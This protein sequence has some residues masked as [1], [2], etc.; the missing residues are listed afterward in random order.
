[1][2]DYIASIGS[3]LLAAFV[4][5][6]TK[7]FADPGSGLSQDP[8][9]WP[10]LLTALLVLLSVLLLVNASRDKKEIRF[11]VNGP[12]LL[13]IGK[14]FA[15]LIVYIAA[16]LLLMPLLDRIFGS[17]PVLPATLLEALIPAVIGTFAVMVTWPVFRDKRVLPAAYIWLTIFALTILIIVLVDL[18][19]EPAAGKA[20]LYFFACEVL[21]GLIIGN[22]AVWLKYRDFLQK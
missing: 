16:Y 15:V 13:N 8:S 12:L 6:S 2:K 21:P 7:E 5:I 19:S 22:L 14:V 10:K 1:M 4:W 18:R 9:Y 11:S 17:G 3:L 20:F